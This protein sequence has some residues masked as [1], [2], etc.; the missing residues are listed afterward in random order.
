MALTAAEARTRGDATRDQRTELKQL[1]ETRRYPKEWRDQLFADIVGDG[2]LTQAR[3]TAVLTWLR[4][5][6]RLDGGIRAAA[7]DIDRILELLRQR[8]APGRWARQIRD[9]ITAGTLTVDE[10]T[11]YLYDLERL[12]KRAFVTPAGPRPG[13]PGT[14]APDGYFGLADA[15]G[16]V[17][18]Y[19]IHT[20]RTGHLAVD[21]FTGEKAGQRRRIHGWQA[22][23]ILRAVA[24]DAAAAARLFATNRHHCS[25]CNQ[26]LHDAT[27]PGFEHGYGPDCWDAR[28]IYLASTEGEA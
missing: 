9:R 2:G 8:I 21:L 11:R 6:A 26:P 10:A 7:V 19:R 13:A 1:L 17:R 23:Q 14:D 16:R 25:G 5:Q 3:V 12:P 20:L 28:R 18:C 24:A 15:D 27:K 4:S 22:T